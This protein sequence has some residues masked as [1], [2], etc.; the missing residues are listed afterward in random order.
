MSKPFKTTKSIK[1]AYLSALIV[2]SGLV[3]VSIFIG[4]RFANTQ[5][6]STSLM[7]VIG[8]QVELSQNLTHHLVQLRQTNHQ[9]M[10]HSMLSKLHQG[11]QQFTANLELLK[12][13]PAFSQAVPESLLDKMQQFIEQNTLAIESNSQQIRR[14]LELVNGEAMYAELKVLLSDVQKQTKNNNQ[15]L[16]WFYTIFPVVI[17]LAALLT[18]INLY[19]RSQR[20]FEHEFERL[21]KETERANLQRKKAE[22]ANQAKSQFLA[23]MSHE[24]R[25][26]LNGVFGMLEIAQSKSAAVEKNELIRKA[27]TSGK[28][29]LTVINDI[30]DIAKIES[31]KITL[32]Y[33]DFCLPQILE[34]ALAPIAIMCEQKSL[35]FSTQVAD[36]VPSFLHG[37]GNRLVQVLT[38]LLN[39][40]VKFTEHGGIRLEVDYTSHGD[41][42]TLLIKIS[43]TGI[44]MSES[45]QKNIFKPFIQGDNST[46]R[47]YGGTGLGLAICSELVNKMSGKLEVSSEV[48]FGS[49]F[50]LTLPFKVSSTIE[51]ELPSTFNPDFD[52]LA[53]RKVAVVDDLA[54]SRKFLTH[55]LAKLNIYPDVY[56]DSKSCLENAD[57]GYDLFIVDLHMPGIDGLELTKQ[58]KKLAQTNNSTRFI[59]LSAIIDHVPELLDEQHIFDFCFSKPMDESRFF[60]AVIDCL[61][62][63]E[64]NHD[65]S[66]FSILVAEDNEV[67]AQIAVHFLQTTGYSVTRVA[68][69]QQ[70]VDACTDPDQSFDLILMDINM[71][72]LDGYQATQIIRNDVMLEVPII[73]LTANAFEEDK[74]KSLNAG[75]DHHLTKPLVKDELLQ[76]IKMSLGETFI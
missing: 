46:T 44:G 70:A 61:S 65:P 24:I 62:H 75:M 29:L 37:P 52:E 55:Q 27:R 22:I 21:R 74:E 25:T 45:Q 64:Q 53:S 50:T 30:L 59:L 68:N 57:K 2:I 32:D 6:Q 72:V 8:Q 12:T 23:N 14:S 7:N 34:E 63:Q 16:F 9:I 60:D 31:N 18:Y 43:D 76:T 69:G 66:N 19:I 26:P 10:Q 17:L 33:F 38:N 20:H 56:E 58:L 73:A 13:K 11:V 15:Q 71:P 4:H 28:Q 1:W 5:K 48:N 39:N 54:V 35:K 67:N 3:L 41:K 51:Q 42:I 49:T 40:A 47:K 36:D